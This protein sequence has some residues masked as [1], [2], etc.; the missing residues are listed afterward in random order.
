[1]PLKRFLTG[2]SYSKAGWL[3]LVLCPLVLWGSWQLSYLEYRIHPENST[4]EGGTDASQGG[5]SKVFD[6]LPQDQ[7]WTFR[8]QL[9]PTAEWPNA[10]LSIKDNAS[11]CM[12]M[13][14]YESLQFELQAAHSKGLTVLAFNGREVLKGTKEEARILYHFIDA[15]PKIQAFDLKL[16]D[17]FVPEWV[18]FEHHLEQKRGELLWHQK[19]E[20]AIYASN[21][22][23]HHRDETIMIRNIRFVGFR[24][25][26]FGISIGLC[27][28]ITLLWAFWAWK[29][30]HPLVAPSSEPRTMPIVLVPI[31]DQNSLIGLNTQTDA[32]TQPENQQWHQCAMWLAQAYR[33]PD[34]STESAAKG[35][36]L[37][38]RRFTELVKTN[39]GLGPKEYITK[40]RIEAA[41]ELLIRSKLQIQEVAYQS[42]FNS[43]PHFNRVFKAETGKSPGDF[44]SQ[45]P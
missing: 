23:P 17:F 5:T 13:T 14:A 18:V 35:V 42:G 7:G 1:M 12:D 45:T 19:C 3:W 30:R 22:T 32:P 28:V 27:S 37:P 2:I 8:L 38:L 43:V 25:W 4:V 36:N 21:Y 15:K 34:L 39:T 16:K 10:G 11:P 29:V 20:I 9:Q 26:L 44:R 6:I 33:D 41:K 31:Q 24:T 40:L